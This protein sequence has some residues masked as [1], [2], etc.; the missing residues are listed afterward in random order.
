MP[1]LHLITTHAGCALSHDDGTVVFEARGRDARR[2]CL[3]H[4]VRCGTLVVH[5]P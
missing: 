1:A 3:L 5:C 4:A 2:T